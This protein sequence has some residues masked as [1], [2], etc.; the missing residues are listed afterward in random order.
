[1]MALATAVARPSARRS[2]GAGR[3]F[4]RVAIECC[5][6]WSMSSLEH[7]VGSSGIK[8]RHLRSG[9]ARKRTSEIFGK[10]GFTTWKAPTMWF[11]T[12]GMR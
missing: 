1:M 4:I 7:V 8:I 11:K 5:G 10:A 12:M 9:G 6:E 2:K 3:R